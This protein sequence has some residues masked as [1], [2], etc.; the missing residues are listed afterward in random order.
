MRYRADPPALLQ[1]VQLDSFTAVYHRQS[2]QTH[3]VVEPVPTILDALGSGEGDVVEILAR[4]EL[5]NT[6][7]TRAALIAHLDDLVA[8]GLVTAS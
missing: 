3:L 4:L 8:T 1:T 2:G 5:E 7:E 6:S